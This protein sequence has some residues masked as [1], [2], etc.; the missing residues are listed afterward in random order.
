MRRWVQIPPLLHSSATLLLRTRRSTSSQSLMIGSTT[1]TG[2]TE[3]IRRILPLPPIPI[4]G[5]ALTCMTTISAAMILRRSRAPTTARIRRPTRTRKRIL[6]RGPPK[7]QVTARQAAA[8][9]EATGRRFIRRPLHRADH[10]TAPH[11]H[12][13][14]ARRHFHT[15]EA[16]SHHIPV[17]PYG[18]DTCARHMRPTTMTHAPDTRA[19]HRRAT[20]MTHAP[21]TCA[22]RP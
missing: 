8:V 9:M 14:T 12:I 4:F 10:R 3:C 17:I 7:H 19:R 21:D 5:P 15:N 13:H 1:R 11:G 18:H 20:A 6:H 22:P 2:P 16:I